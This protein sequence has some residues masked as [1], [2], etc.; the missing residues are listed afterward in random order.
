MLMPGE[1]IFWL[2]LGHVGGQH[3]AETLQRAVAADGEVAGEVQRMF[4][5]NY[6]Q[7]QELNQSDKYARVIQIWYV[8]EPNIWG[9]NRNMSKSRLKK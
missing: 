6:I 5:G 9:L 4:S 2:D 1:A 3:A 7:H 8:A